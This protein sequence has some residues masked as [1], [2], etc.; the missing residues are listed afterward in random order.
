[1]NRNRTVRTREVDQLVDEEAQRRADGKR[2]HDRKTT[3][4]LAEQTKVS[5]GYLTQLISRRR[6]Q[7][8]EKVDVSRGAIV[9]VNSTASNQQNSESELPA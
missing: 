2:M 1:M 4:Q 5:Y 8:E 3:K 6:R 7:L 9:V